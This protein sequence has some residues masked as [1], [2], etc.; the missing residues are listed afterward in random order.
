MNMISPTTRTAPAPILRRARALVYLLELAERHGLPMPD[1]AEPGSGN[2][3]MPAD[4]VGPSG[5]PFDRVP[6]DFD[7]L[8]DLVDWAMWAEAVVEDV[9]GVDGQHLGYGFDATI[10]DIPVHARYFGSERR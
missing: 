1:D 2:V 9:T 5:D 7:S 6:L 4:I 3:V 8:A 10:D